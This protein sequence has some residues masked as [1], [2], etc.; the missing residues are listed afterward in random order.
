MRLEFE[1]TRQ[2]YYEYNLFQFKKKGIKEHVVTVVV[3]LAAII[4]LLNKQQTDIPGTIIF[5]VI[6]I[7][8]YFWSVWQSLQKSKQIPMAGGGLL[9]E[10]V[11]DFN[12]DEIIGTE[13]N[14][15]T[16]FTWAAIKRMEEGL[17]GIYLFVDA[18]L[19][20]VIPTRCFYGNVSKKEFIEFVERKMSALI[21]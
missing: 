15:Y 20:I 12:E 14:S 1:M 19:A 4:L 3:W 18:N 6:F 7:A 11:Y 21:E 8:G 17:Q 13:R 5:T 2:D 10:K 16:R 9:G